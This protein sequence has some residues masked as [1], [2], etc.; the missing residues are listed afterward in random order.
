MANANE[1]T[2]ERDG[3]LNGEAARQAEALTSDTPSIDSASSIGIKGHR[4]M[5]YST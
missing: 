2:H 5:Q 3:K 1:A 4:A